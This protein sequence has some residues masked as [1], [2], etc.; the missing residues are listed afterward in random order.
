MKAPSGSSQLAQIARLV[1][2]FE[3]LAR[4]DTH[5]SQVLGYSNPT[6]VHKI[7]RGLT[8]M[9]SD[10]LAK[11]AELEVKQGYFPNLHWVLTG[12]FLAVVSSLPDPKELQYLHRWATDLAHENLVA[13]LDQRYPSGRRARAEDR[14]IISEI[15]GRLA[16]VLRGPIVL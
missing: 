10:R 13:L 5:L 11:L 14:K 6:T 16:R 1:A 9:G 8:F 7:R 4:G 15:E 2:T 12:S 3:L